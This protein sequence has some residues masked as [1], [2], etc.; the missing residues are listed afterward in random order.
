MLDGSRLDVTSLPREY[1][2]VIGVLSEST[3]NAD[4]PF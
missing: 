4:N 3:V 1:L 2:E